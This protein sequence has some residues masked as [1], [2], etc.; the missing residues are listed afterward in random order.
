MVQLIRSSSVSGIT[1]VSVS[2]SNAMIAASPHGASIEAILVAAERTAAT[3]A[4][5][6]EP[7]A[8]LIDYPF[9]F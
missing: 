1:G 8:I 7:S 4:A 6:E 3:L 2:T 9:A 5:H